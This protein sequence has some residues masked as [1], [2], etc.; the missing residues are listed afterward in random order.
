MR[1]FLAIALPPEVK[2][3]IG[4]IQERLKKSVPGDI[5]WVRPEGVHLTLKF[6]GEMTLPE[7]ERIKAAVA[8]P[9][10]AAAPF[11]LEVRGLGAFPEVSRPRVIWLGLAG[12]TAALMSL[13]GELERE[14]ARAG[15]PEEE[16]PFRAHLTLG[17]V[18]IPKGVLGLARTVE[19]ETDMAAGRI[20]VE[21]IV[22]FKS[23][24]TPRGAIHTRLAAFPLR[25]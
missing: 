6:F 16:R 13:R 12:E 17:R 15:F 1:A 7:L 25:G 4:R 8:G 20:P 11:V 5:R 23:E 24:L 14:L 3:N 19:T 18:K 2:A 10:A 9:T 22:L 21:E